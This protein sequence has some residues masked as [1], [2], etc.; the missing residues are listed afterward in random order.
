MRINWRS[1][2]D[3]ETFSGQR[4]KGPEKLPNAPHPEG[5]LEII[6]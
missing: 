1:E 6:L 2:E 3:G 5:I 4:E